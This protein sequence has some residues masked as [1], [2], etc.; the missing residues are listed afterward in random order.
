[1]KKEPF[2]NSYPNNILTNEY[3]DLVYDY[4][5]PLVFGEAKDIEEDNIR[6]LSLF[7]GCGGMDLGF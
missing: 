2:E 1:M 3:S 4:Q 7:F 5:I 6:V